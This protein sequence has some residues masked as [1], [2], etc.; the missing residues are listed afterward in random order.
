MDPLG[1][2]MGNPWE[3]LHKIRYGQPAEQMPALIAA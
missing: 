3:I 2:L 1:K